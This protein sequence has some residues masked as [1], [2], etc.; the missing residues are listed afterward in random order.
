MFWPCE[1]STSTCRSFATISS[2]LYRFLAITVL[3]DVKDIPQVGPLQWGRITIPTAGPGLLAGSASG[4]GSF[5]VPVPSGAPPSSPSDLSSFNLSVTT[6]GSSTDFSVLP[7]TTTIST[8]NFNYSRGDLTSFSFNPGSPNATVVTP[9]LTPNPSVLGI[10]S[11][12]TKPVDGSNPNF[13]PQSVSVTGNQARTFSTVANTTKSFVAVNQ[14]SLTA[15]IVQGTVTVATGGPTSATGQNTSTQAKFTPNFGLTL[16][17][18][19]TLM[20]FTGFNWVQT[21]NSWPSPTTLASNNAPNTP[22]SFP[23]KDPPPGGWSYV[24]PISNS[25]PFY[26]KPA[27]TG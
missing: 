14:A 13:Y 1:A 12:N 21:I 25:Y 15:A 11:F 9:P 8:S 16:A 19:A 5:T 27:F 23:T 10:I 3:L 18:A 17:Q 24:R 26:Y 20:G 22:V 2:G 4:D 7:P 6:T